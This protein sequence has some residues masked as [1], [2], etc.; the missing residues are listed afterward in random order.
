MHTLTEEYSLNISRSWYS[1]EHVLENASLSFLIQYS[2]LVSI[3]C[4]N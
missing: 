2:F 3:G 1:I 4:T